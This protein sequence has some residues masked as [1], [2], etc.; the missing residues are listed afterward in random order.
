VQS[1]CWQEL[2][3]APGGMVTAEMPHGGLMGPG[4][5]VKPAMVRLAQI[6]GAIKEGKSPL[7]ALGALMGA[8]VA[9]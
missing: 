3:D 2:A 6:R 8:G 5:I 7:A 4:G 1:V 9:R